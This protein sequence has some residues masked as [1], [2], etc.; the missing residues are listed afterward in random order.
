MCIQETKCEEYPA[1]LYNQGYHIHSHPS[2]GSAGG[3]LTLISLKWG[4]NHLETLREERDV[5]WSSVSL[6]KGCGSI[7]VANTYSRSNLPLQDVMSTI[8]S[9]VVRLTQLSA[10]SNA[11]KVLVGD[12]NIDHQRQRDSERYIKVPIANF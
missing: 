6:G 8:G 2:E 12:L 5:C 1:F 10:A 3:L 7:V 11:H 4:A 9:I